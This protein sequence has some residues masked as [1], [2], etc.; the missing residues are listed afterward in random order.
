MRRSIALGLCL[1]GLTGGAARAQDPPSDAPTRMGR[2]DW[3][4]P[5]FLLGLGVEGYTGKLAPNLDPGP[6]YGVVVGYRANDYVGLELGYS[7]GVSSLS[8]ADSSDFFG[9]PDLVRNGAQAALTIGFTPTRLQPYVL[10]GIGVE[11]Y[12]VREGSFFRF[13]DDTG[14]YA[15]VGAG[16]RFKINPQLTAEVRGSYSFLFG[17][18]FAPSQDIG[19]GDGRY[20]G[21]LM[22]GGS[23]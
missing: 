14:G 18:N 17:Q 4:G 19:A 20:S 22:I 3:Q 11:R 2:V 16:V 7:G 8:V 13:F 10:G 1:A 23:Y 6:S 12:S 9:T 5:Y 15:P 21:L